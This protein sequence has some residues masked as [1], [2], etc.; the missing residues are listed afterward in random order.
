[1]CTFKC[2]EHLT[3]MRRMG[4]EGKN[5]PEWWAMSNYRVCVD[6]PQQGLL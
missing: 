2:E 1:M 4:G 5:G 3:G 6:K